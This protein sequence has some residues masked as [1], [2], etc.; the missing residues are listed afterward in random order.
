MKQQNLDQYDVVIKLHTY[1]NSKKCTRS[2]MSPQSQALKN[3]QFIYI[4]LTTYPNI[5]KSTNHPTLYITDEAEVKQFFGMLYP[6][7]QTM[8]SVIDSQQN[9]S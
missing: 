2:Y 8:R 4:Y 3:G 9:Q 1:L 5:D 6:F 7:Y